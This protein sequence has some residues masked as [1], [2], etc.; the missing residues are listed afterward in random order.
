MVTMLLLCVRTAEAAI[1]NATVTVLTEQD[2]SDIWLG[3]ST[4]GYDLIT[5]LSSTYEFRVFVKNGMPERALHNVKIAPNNFP[6]AINSITPS[7][8]QEIKPMEIVIFWVNTSIPSNATVGKYA[9]R[10]DVSSDEFPAGVFSLSSEIKVVKNIKTW[11]YALYAFITLLI[12][13]VFF[14]RKRKILLEEKKLGRKT[15]E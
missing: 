9:I 7:S 2:Y 10:F 1:K 3:I 14:Y 5:E 15:R 12:L 13:V 4:G 8:F 6:F 11:L